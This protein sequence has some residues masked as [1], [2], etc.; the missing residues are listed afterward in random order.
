MQETPWLADQDQDFD[1]GP[2]PETPAPPPLPADGLDP[3][4]PVPDGG[5]WAA[6]EWVAVVL[7]DGDRDMPPGYVTREWLDGWGRDKGWTEAP[8]E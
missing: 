5:E 3:T 7:K 6:Q 8:T 4:N 2:L 1:P